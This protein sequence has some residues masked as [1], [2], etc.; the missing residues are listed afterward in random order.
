MT[1]VIYISNSLNLPLKGSAKNCSTHTFWIFLFIII[2]FREV[3]HDIS[4]E[5]STWQMINL[6]CQD[7]IL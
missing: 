3:S 5:A 7:F 2:F 6:K 1:L 4:F